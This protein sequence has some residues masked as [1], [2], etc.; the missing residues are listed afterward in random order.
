[1]YQLTIY[2][3]A[4]AKFRCVHYFPSSVN[5]HVLDILNVFLKELVSNSN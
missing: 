4:V 5:R 2:R 3:V 1:M